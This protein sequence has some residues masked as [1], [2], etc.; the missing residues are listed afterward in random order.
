MQLGAKSY[1]LNLLE[2]PIKSA[3][4]YARHTWIRI[5]IRPSIFHE[6]VDTCCAPRDPE[7]NDFRLLPRDLS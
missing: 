2:I 7:M 5:R 3:I 1:L 4:L 6:G